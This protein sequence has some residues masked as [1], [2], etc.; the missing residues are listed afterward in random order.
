M[1]L[2]NAEDLAFNGDEVRDFAEAIFEQLYE[3]PVIDQNHLI[4]EDIVAKTQIAI[5]GHLSK[6]TKKDP[7]CGLGKVT[8]SIPLSEKFW[9]PV[10]MKIWLS[11][12][13]TQ[14]DNT[15]MVY[16]KRK[17]REYPDLTTTE[18]FSM[19]LV[20]EVAQ[21]A[22]EDLL[23]IAYFADTAADEVSDGGVFKNGTD[24]TDYTQLDGFWKQAFAIVAAN[25]K[26]RVPVARN[27]GTMLAPEEVIIQG[28]ASGGTLAAGTYYYKV[29]AV[30]SSNVSL[31][32]QEVSVTTSGSSSSV[33][34]TWQPVEGATGYRIYRG[35]ASN[36]QSA[37]QT[38]TNPTFTDTGAA[39]TAGTPPVTATAK[40]YAYQVFTEEDTQNR[41]ATKIYQDLVF[42]A[43]SRF[44]GDANFEI[45]STR[46]LADQYIR[47]RL[48]N[49][50]LEVVYN[51]EE[52]GIETL[53]VLGKK[54]F[55]YDIWDRTIQADQDNG[56]T[57]N[58]PHRAL[59]INKNNMQVDIVG[60][61]SLKDFD[62]FYD[63][64][65][66]TSNIKGGYKLDVKIV[67]NWRLMAAY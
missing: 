67:E 49:D 36:S 35:T 32:G 58:L 51:R 54:V 55:I 27:A 34:L 4:V 16:Y 46:S 59:A 29:V 10:Q 33:V 6:I 38:S 60:K 14:F 17:T 20:D 1:S 26:Q 47:E 30:V 12:C 50:K 52:S 63:K 65:S 62:V 11:E 57:L 43:D 18:I 66:E 44:R 7:G 15:F 41:V 53:M 23:R 5:F 64:M 37:Y 2:I 3:N 31:P 28:N 39:G 24:L 25:P 45:L 56:V 48:N 61:E 40:G 19:W 22:A 13:H 21:A 42:K 9:D 8:K